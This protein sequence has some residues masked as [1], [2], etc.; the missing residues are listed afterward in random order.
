MVELGAP[1]SLTLPSIDER[2]ARWRA[3][4]A[5]M[6]SSGVPAALATAGMQ[7]A[8]DGLKAGRAD[9]AIETL[10]LLVQHA[11]D[12]D[13]A[14][15]L[16]G[17]AY[18]EEQHVAEATAAFARAC[19]LRPDDI[20]SALGH[21][22]VSAEAGIPAVA[23]FRRALALA[24][25]SLPALRGLGLTLAGD[26]RPREAEQLFDDALARHPGWLEGH[27]CLASLRWTL[28]GER[29]FA[30]S[31]AAAC[32]LQPNNL[33]LRLAWF[34]A[35]A[36]T[37]DWEAARAIVADAERVLGSS[38]ALTVARLFVAS[39]SGDDALADQLFQQTEALRDDVRDIAYVRFCLRAGRAERAEQAA[40]RLLGT[41]SGYM[42][43]PY[44][45]LIW[46]LLGDSRAQ[47]LEGAPPF[48]RAI[49]LD[50][51][52]HDLSLLAAALRRLHTAQAP[53]LEQ[54]VRGGT[55]TDGQLFFRPE[56]VIQAAKIQIE[57][58]VQ[59]YVAGLPKNGP[60]HPL[61]GPPRGGR[62][63]YSGSWSVRLQAG[64][65][66]VAHTHPMGW[67]SSAFYVELPPAAQLGRS[68]SGW[69]T[70]GEP[71]PELGLQLGAHAQVEPKPGR[72][73]LFPSFMWHRTLPFDAGERLVVAF[74][75]RRPRS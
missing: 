34:R 46:R 39:E 68:P 10:R 35:V 72:L 47:W 48:I 52:A 27:R 6:D 22:Q 53:Y 64:G 33:A 31:Y 4:L 13:Q 60:A 29:D 8:R 9:C 45:S 61:L 37:R 73:V 74:D 69:I 58:G 21:A 20:Q 71:P 3:S 24:P 50:F 36:Q 43:W 40:V 41:P 56:P 18:R 15:Q 1:G 17:Y 12:A 25:E 65:H 11:P 16:L 30:R 32:R 70:F 2:F 7:L 67:I 5:A 54:S 26:G 14:W 23:L 59:Q 44:L 28:A 42:M 55:Q 63:L 51:S 38:P 62:L 75:V 49:D 57:A 19:R 66:H